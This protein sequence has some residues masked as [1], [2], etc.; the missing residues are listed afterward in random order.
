MNPLEHP[1]VFAAPRR[2]ARV[3]A[4]R[5]HIPFGMLLVDL[6]R[7]RTLVELGTH[8]GNSYCGFCQAVAELRLDTRCYAVDTWE[9]DEHSGRYGP[10]V[11]A[12]LRAHHDPLYASFSRLLQCTFDQAASDFPDGSIDLL[13]LDGYHTYDSVKHD[14]ESWLPKVSG[15]GILLLHDINA[16]G[17]RDYGAWRVWEELKP[18]YPHFEVHHA[19]GLGVLVSGSDPPPGV[20][21]LVELSPED[22]ASLR[23]LLF[24]LGYRLRLLLLLEDT[25]TKRRELSHRLA[26]TRR[27]AADVDGAL[28]ALNGEVG[29]LRAEL[30]ESS[31]TYESAQAELDE[32]RRRKLVRLGGQLGRLRQAAR[33]VSQRGRGAS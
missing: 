23:D 13:H 12:D 18:R 24:H 3:S 8:W 33:E 20:R 28:R 14:V 29:A 31:R 16:R 26:S 11:L 1:I 9:G 2:L 7:P 21:E 4:W 25:R 30:V 10:E 19:H 17:R 22:A 32:L 5:E 27:E 15:R 6:A